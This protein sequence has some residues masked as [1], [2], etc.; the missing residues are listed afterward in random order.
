M[1]TNILVFKL[2]QLS[3]KEDRKVDETDNNFIILIKGI[4]P[5]EIG[6]CTMKLRSLGNVR[7][8]LSQKLLQPQ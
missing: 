2:S 4:E 1:N 6:N 7:S 5:M 3:L 8:K